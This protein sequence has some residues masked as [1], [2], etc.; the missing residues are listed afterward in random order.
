[1]TKKSSPSIISV[2]RYP[3]NNVMSKSNTEKGE[4]TK[5]EVGSIDCKKHVKEHKNIGAHQFKT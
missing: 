5:R 4:N 1:M 3:K 2:A